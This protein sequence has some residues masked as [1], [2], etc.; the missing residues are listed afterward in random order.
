[1]ASVTALSTFP[2]PMAALNL[3]PVFSKVS[4][5]I[6]FVYL[7]VR[8]NGRDELVRGKSEMGG[9]ILN[10]ATSPS[11]VAGYRYTVYG[12]S[13]VYCLWFVSLFI[14]LC[15]CV[16]VCLKVKVSHE[17]CGHGRRIPASN[18]SHTAGG[19]QHANNNM[20]DSTYTCPSHV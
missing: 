16:C 12:N 10:I 11:S 9:K 20:A 15:V 6:P 2:S 14:A 18:S 3:S 1:M 4:Q 7:W 19:T 8:G 13:G 5:H 17:L